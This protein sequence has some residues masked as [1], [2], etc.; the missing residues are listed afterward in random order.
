MYYN[1]MTLFRSGSDGYHT[2]RIPSLLA[3]KGGTL[4]AF[5]EGRKHGRSDAGEIDMVMRRSEDDGHTWGALEV[6]VTESQMTCGN[7]CPVQDRDTDVIWM[8]FNKNLADGDENLITQGKAPRTVWMTRSEDD[9]RTWS[10]PV[11]I[12]QSVKK[13]EWTWYATGPGHGIQLANGRLLIPCDHIVGV[14]F[15]RLRD[16]YHS[17]VIVSDDHGATW[18][19]GGIVPVGTNESM[20]L[21]TVDGEVYLNARNF[22]GGV[23]RGVVRSNDGGDSFDRL[24]WDEILIEPSC[25]ASVIRYST[26][27]QGGRNRVLFS[28]PAS[29]TRERMTVRLSY[30]ECRTWPV[31]KLLYAGPSAYSD[32]ATLPDGKICCLYEC[33]DESLYEE[34]RLARFDLDWLTDGADATS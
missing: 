20:A 15:E 2:F 6:V 13:S 3:T 17:H 7:P 23:Q 31:A 24:A 21:E 30:D 32:L 26:S 27:A 1:D 29:T 12:T 5:A 14:H 18:R 34:L 4:L 28:N 8:P 16:P 11:E 25:Q 9:G 22:I 33:G 10:E 19:I